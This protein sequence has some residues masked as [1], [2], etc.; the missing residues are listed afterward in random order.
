MEHAVPENRRLRHR[1]H[2]TARRIYGPDVTGDHARATKQLQWASQ[3]ERCELMYR[4]NM[5]DQGS[6]GCSG[7]SK[8]CL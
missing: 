1:G 4:Y 8:S 6:T 7:T 5:D 3:G 2:I